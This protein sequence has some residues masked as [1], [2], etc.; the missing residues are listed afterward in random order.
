MKSSG[1]FKSLTGPDTALST[2]V[3][4]GSSTWALRLKDPAWVESPVWMTSK[5]TPSAT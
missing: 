3:R 5:N 4:E 2:Q 1:K